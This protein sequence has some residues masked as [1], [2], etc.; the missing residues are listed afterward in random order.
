[1]VNFTRGN[2]PVENLDAVRL[3]DVTVDPISPISRI[4]CR[5]YPGPPTGLPELREL[6]A[7]QLLGAPADWTFVGNH[8]S[9]GLY[10]D[11]LTLA[12]YRGLPGQKPWIDMQ[13]LG[14][15]APKILIPEPAY[16][17]HMRRLRW[18]G[19][20]LVPVPMNDNGPNMDV[21]EDLVRDPA[22]VGIV[23]VPK[24]SNPGGETYADDVVRR[25]AYMQTGNNGFLI[26]WDLAY[27]A[28]G[29]ADACSDT[30]ANIFDLCREAHTEDRVFAFG[31]TSKITYAASGIACMAASPRNIE[32]YL[33]DLA[34][35]E[36]NPDK[37][38]QLS[39]YRFLSEVGIAD[40]MRRHAQVLLPRAQAVYDVVQKRL[41]PKGLGSCTTPR[42]GYF[43]CVQT[44]GLAKRA[45]EIAAALGFTFTP[46]GSAFVSGIDP[47]NALVRVCFTEHPPETNALGTEVLCLGAEIAA[48][49][50][51]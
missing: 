6:L 40:L 20:V 19:F 1:M 21:V 44:P 30:L 3:P 11:V 48:W 9:L 12:L 5:N 8:S 37:M 31:S 4:D 33:A 18:L 50:Q 49:E 42:G 46:V 27:A 29:L 36:I 34:T 35:R 13:R 47:R 23:C 43:L 32:W 15:H 25:L 39:H 7:L 2:P 41:V 22:V 10:S 38:R 51:A 24:H 17:R 14:W 26:L 16:D 28:H 45:V